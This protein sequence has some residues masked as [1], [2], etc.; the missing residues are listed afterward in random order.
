VKVY[1]DPILFRRAVSNLLS[2]AL[3]Y[4]AKGGEITMEAKGEADG[5]VTISVKNP[6]PG[7]SPVHLARIFD[8]FYR[9]EPAREKSRRGAGLGLAIVRTIMRLHGGAVSVA[10]NEF[11]VFTLRFPPAPAAARV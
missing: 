7:I 1:A 8:R 5:S 6:G 11:T 3:R 2:N 10:S 9:T 4:A